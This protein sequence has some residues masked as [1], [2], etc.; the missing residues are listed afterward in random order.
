MMQMGRRSDGHSIDAELEQRL[1][2]VDR[3]AAE[4]AGHQIALAAIGIGDADELDAG[5]P[6]QNPG[7][8]GAHG[9]DADDADPQRCTTF[10]RLHHG[11]T[12]PP[13]RTCPNAPEMSLARPM[14]TG[15]R[16]LISLPNTF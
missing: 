13:D 1:H 10:Y 8:I 5:Q 11:Q 2:I 12:F 16:N 15:D 4:H 7:M 14:A 6:G 3:R 9:A